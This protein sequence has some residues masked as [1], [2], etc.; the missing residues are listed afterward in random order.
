MTRKIDATRPLYAVVGAGDL[1][2]EYARNA[3]ADVQARFAKIEL[4]P[5]AL[6][7]QA[8]TVVTA[9][10]D[11]LTTDAKEARSTVESRVKDARTTAETRAKEARTQLET[12]L[13]DAVAE[14]NETYGELAVRGKDLVA[15]I[16]RQQATQDAKAATKSTVT[17]AKTAKTQTKKSA[18]GTAGTAKA[19]TKSTAGSAKKTAGTAKRAAKSTSTSAK[20]AA[21]ATTK[22][23]GDAAE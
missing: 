8:R 21:S 7:D 18:K 17:R 23:A 9:R 22:A 15:R 20:K 12:A 14:V 19:A 3:T 2:V 5:K 6:R 13:N 1:A 4:E 11:G 16:R 10:I